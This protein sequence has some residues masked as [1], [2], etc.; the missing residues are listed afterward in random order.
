LPLIK[1][2]I[3]GGEEPTT[4]W[5]YIHPLPALQ[6][7]VPPWQLLTSYEVSVVRWVA[8]G[9]ARIRVTFV[10]SPVIPTTPLNDIPWIPLVFSAFIA[11]VD[12]L[13]ESICSAT[14]WAENIRGIRGTTGSPYQGS[15]SN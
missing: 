13:T 14:I 3:I 12:V 15:R 11:K 9:I 5:I 2:P 8:K 4:K 7:A 6:G 1:S 10:A